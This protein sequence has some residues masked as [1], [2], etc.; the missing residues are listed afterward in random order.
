MIG[1]QIFDR[2]EKASDVFVAEIAND[3]DISRED[4]CPL[5]K[6]SQPAAEHKLHLGLNE[7]AGDGF[8]IGHGFDRGQPGGLRLG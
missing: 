3:I 7:S 5:K 4:R 2:L 6:G 1:M 8:Q